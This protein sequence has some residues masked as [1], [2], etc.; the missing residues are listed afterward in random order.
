MLD[1]VGPTPY[2]KL[3]TSADRNTPAGKLYYNK[4]G[5]LKKLDDDFLDGVAD[6]L[7][8]ASGQEDPA[9]ASNVILQHLGGAVGDVAPGDTAYVHRD[10]IYDSI[11]LSGWDNPAYNEQNID[12][13][14]DSF[15]LME[16]HTIG[17]YSNHMVD[18][19]EPKIKRAFRDNYD[20][21]VKL[22]NKYDPD[23][24]FHLNP[25]VKPTA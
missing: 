3:Q 12:W 11:I 25:N 10:A 7:Q 8:G 18:S 17:F 19:D 23:N 6:R 9:V 1:Q 22:K 13:L 5:L 21:L 14:K 2:N 24:L 20:Q 15:T 16:P 4:S